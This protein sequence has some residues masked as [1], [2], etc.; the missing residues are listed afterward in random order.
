MW[1]SFQTITWAAQD[2]IFLC[3]KYHEKDSQAHRIVL[4][5]KNSQWVKICS[6]LQR[7][8]VKNC[9]DVL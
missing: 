7:Q 4:G 9:I 8:N 3:Y 2:F 5:M 6:I 1:E